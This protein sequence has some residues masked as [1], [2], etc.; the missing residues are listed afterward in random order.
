ML[1]SQ[2]N[3]AMAGAFDLV[4]FD[5]KGLDG[6]GD[7]RGICAYERVGT[8]QKKIKKTKGDKDKQKNRTLKLKKRAQHFYDVIYKDP[9]LGGTLPPFGIF[10]ESFLEYK[11]ERDGNKDCYSWSDIL[12]TVVNKFGLPDLSK[13]YEHFFDEIP[14]PLYGKTR[15]SFMFYLALWYNI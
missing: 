4:V 3:Q 6:Y 15:R 8:L 12:D 14:A 2:K 13:Y 7:F 10:F 9:E 1:V 5:F 11:D